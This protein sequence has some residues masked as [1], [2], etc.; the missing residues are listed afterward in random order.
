[1]LILLMAIAIFLLCCLEV[2]LGTK[3]SYTV[4]YS[5]L[6]NSESWN[7]DNII[8]TQVTWIYNTFMIP[9]K[10]PLCCFLILIIT[11]KLLLTLFFW[12]FQYYYSRCDYRHIII[13]MQIK[14][15]TPTYC[16]FLNSIDGSEQ[17]RHKE[18]F[19]QYKLYRIMLMAWGLPIPNCQK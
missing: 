18:N 4:M 14:H 2:T 13:V 3:I 15:K 1:M 5:F 7:P 10:G 16:Q 11:K 8:F 19:T 12:Y 6:V 9:K 17:R